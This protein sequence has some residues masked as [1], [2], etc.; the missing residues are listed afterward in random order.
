MAIA[1]NVVSLRY[2]HAI[3]VPKMI[4]IPHFG[5]IGR[6]RMFYLGRPFWQMCGEPSGVI[7]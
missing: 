5:G 1:K 2:R 4:T 3:S 7:L 6:T